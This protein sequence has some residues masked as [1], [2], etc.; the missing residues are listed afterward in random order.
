MKNLLIDLP[1][2][3]SETF[4]THPSFAVTKVEV[5][6]TRTIQVKQF[7]PLSPSVTVHVDIFDMATVQETIRAVMADAR[8]AVMEAFAYAVP[9]VAVKL[10]DD[11][12]ADFVAK[13]TPSQLA[14]MRAALQPE[15]VASGIQHRRPQATPSGL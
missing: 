1:G 12:A 8:N 9:A 14:A 7:E 3:E 4:V 11:F 13:A 2:E 5:T 10:G 15:G 6:Y